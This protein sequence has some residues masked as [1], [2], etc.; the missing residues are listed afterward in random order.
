LALTASFLGSVACSSDSG[1]TEKAGNVEVFSWWTAGGEAEALQA[2][3]DLHSVEYPKVTV[4]NAATALGD[5]ARATLRTR[6]ENAEPPDLFQANIG[7]DLLQWAGAQPKIE[8][9]DTIAE[10]EGWA[11]YPDVVAQ[12][13]E[14][15][16]STY[17][18]PVNIH[19]INTLFVNLPILA[20]NNVDPASLNTLAGLEA[21]LTALDADTALVA[22]INI[23]S[24]YQWTLDIMILESI[25]P[26]VAGS[27]A[28]ENYFRGGSTYDDPIITDML[29][30]AG[31]IWAHMPTGA[32]APNNVDWVPA[33]EAFIR[34]E[35]AMTVMGDW[36]KG[37]IDNSTI[38][39]L[40]PGTDYDAIPF[41]AASGT[42]PYVYTADTFALP[43][44][45]KERI[46]AIDFLKTLG[47]DEAQVAFNQEKGSIPARPLSAASVAGFDVVAQ[48]AITA[49]ESSEHG[50]ALSGIVPGDFN[51]P[52]YQALF[53]WAATCETGTCDPTVVMTALQANYALLSQ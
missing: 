4:T 18:V 53:D 20:R 38:A 27:A 36:A 47:S 17:G 42:A 13:S 1:T 50:L 46:L 30:T 35:V 14:A 29:D 6:M 3:I 52:I 15:D 32:S 49:W 26:A 33:I 23:G 21:A 12:L 16:G 19:R 34:G 40:V 37:L 7:A 22:P 43:V 11:F 28:Y 24:Q 39:T 48:R 51:G 2:V 10:G 45:A 31:R 41:P 5:Q 8:K 25:L 44:G 9:I